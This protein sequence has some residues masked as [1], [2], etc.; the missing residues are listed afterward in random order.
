M[1]QFLKEYY[2]DTGLAANDIGA[3]AY[4]TKGNVVDLWGLGSIE[5]SKSRKHKYWNADFLDSLSKQEGVKVAVIY[6]SW[7]N[8][9]FK[10]KWQKIATWQ[11]PDN[12]VCGDDIVSFYAVDPLHASDL[13]SNLMTYQKKLPAE[14]EVRYY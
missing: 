14:V 9:S 1:G 4:F 13:K 8:N 11:I 10:N 3:V 2:P 5:V 7:F 12:V 6:D